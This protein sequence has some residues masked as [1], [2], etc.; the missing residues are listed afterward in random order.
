L[1]QRR[2]SGLF[3]VRKAIEGKDNIAG[4]KKQWLKSPDRIVVLDEGFKFT[5]PQI[6]P[7]EMQIIETQA[8]S[9]EVARMFNIAPHKI[10]SSTVDQ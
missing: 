2:S 4:W 1:K 6:T 10:K 9:I 8:F 5:P 3:L 7:Q